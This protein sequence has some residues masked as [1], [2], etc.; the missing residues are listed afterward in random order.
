[1]PCQTRRKL[2]LAGPLI[3]MGMLGSGRGR[4]SSDISGESR[5]ILVFLCHGNGTFAS[6][7]LFRFCGYGPFMLASELSWEWQAKYAARPSGHT[8]KRLGIMSRNICRAGGDDLRSL[9]TLPSVAVPN[10]IPPR[11]AFFPRRQNDRC[12]GGRLACRRLP[13]RPRHRLCRP[14]Q[15]SIASRRKHRRTKETG[16]EAFRPAGYC[17]VTC[18]E[19]LCQSMNMAVRILMM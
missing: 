4:G 3:C 5:P 8:A 12:V 16:R 14:W 10:D 17:D 11:P 6:A 13:L 1:M 19:V 2:T 7:D 18:T 15:H 9:L